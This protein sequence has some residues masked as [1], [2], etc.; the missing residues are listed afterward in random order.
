MLWYK[1]KTKKNS[2]SRH[3]LWR[4]RQQ[5]IDTSILTQSWLARGT[6]LVQIY[7][8]KLLNDPDFD[9]SIPIVDPDLA[10]RWIALVF[11]FG[12][13]F[14]RHSHTELQPSCLCFSFYF[15][16][17]YSSLPCP[18]HSGLV[19]WFFS[20]WLCYY[21]C[22]SSIFVWLNSCQPYLPFAFIYLSILRGSKWATIVLLSVLCNVSKLCNVTW[23]I[24][25]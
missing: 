8:Y 2:S 20:F 5:R 15:F 21:S 3:R 16:S 11:T 25:K 24:I 13:L 17:L 23:L 10:Y 7:L 4:H 18:F 19:Y 12:L 6:N 1:K 14:S 22:L 9:Q